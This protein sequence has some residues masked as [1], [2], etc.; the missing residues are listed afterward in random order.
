MCSGARN[1]MASYQYGLLIQ[2]CADVIL[3]WCV[4]EVALAAKYEHG[5]SVLWQ[6]EA[7]EVSHGACTRVCADVSSAK[8]E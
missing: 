7:L 4:M 1:G 8:P 6:G 2:F 3:A 5:K